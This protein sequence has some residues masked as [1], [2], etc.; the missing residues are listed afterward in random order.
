M[1]NEEMLITLL[2]YSRRATLEIAKSVKENYAE[3]ADT[4]PEGFNN[5]IRW[6]LGHI[7]TITDQLSSYPAGEKFELPKPFH[8]SFGFGTSPKNWNNET[9]SL[10]EIIQILEKQPKQITEK[11]SKR[12][13]H[14]LPK[15]FELVGVE[16]KTVGELLAFNLHHE[17]LH[18][19]QIKSMI[20]FL[21]ASK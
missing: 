4:I 6:N 7:A 11:Y 13:F 18:C 9:P 2:N 19:G 21:K 16:Y 8:K 20:H 17:G 3:F 5:N 12:L 10:E 14:P 15:P 1:M